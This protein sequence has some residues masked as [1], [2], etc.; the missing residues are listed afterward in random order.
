MR[1]I[2]LVSRK[3]HYCQTNGH[4]TDDIGFTDT[5]YKIWTNF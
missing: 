1:Y 5:V 2:R 3:P 4:L